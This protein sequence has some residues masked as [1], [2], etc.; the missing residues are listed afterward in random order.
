MLYAPS[1]C[2]RPYPLAN[3]NTHLWARLQRWPAKTI[4]K[5]TQHTSALG[6]SRSLPLTLARSNGAQNARRPGTARANVKR[7]TGKSTRNPATS[8]LVPLL[9]PGRLMGWTLGDTTT[10]LLIP[11]RKRKNWPR[12][13]MSLSPKEAK[14]AWGKYPRRILARFQCAK[15]L[16]FAIFQ[17]A[18][19]TS[20]YN[21]LGYR[22]ESSPPVRS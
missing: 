17:V 22:W 2:P 5:L 6:A 4:P 20:S 11:Y 16:I 7:Q 10:M 19:P 13:W 8:H 1:L 3:T 15:V 18:G 12:H 14:K 21:W 9:T